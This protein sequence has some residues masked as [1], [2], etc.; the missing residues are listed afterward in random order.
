MRLV[1]ESTA[2]AAVATC[3]ANVCGWVGGAAP[4]VAAS[5]A[6]MGWPGGEVIVYDFSGYA[7]DDIA[8]YT[9]IAAAVVAALG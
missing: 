5:W 2:A 9:A 6:S 4:V 7:I 3:R 1:A 8:P